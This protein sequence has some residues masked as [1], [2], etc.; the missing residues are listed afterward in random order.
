MNCT[1]YKWEKSKM[2]KIAIPVYEDMVAPSFDYSQK[3]LLVTL[4]NDKEIKRE[5]ILLK[6]FNSLQKAVRISDLRVEVLIC[7]AISAFA[8]RMLMNNGIRVIP[9]I[10]GEIDKIIKLYIQGQF[11]IERFRMLWGRF[12]RHFPGRRKRWRHR[13]PPPW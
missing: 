9:M 11:N 2:M 12:C 10:S 6:D 1:T 3:V 13:I 4:E 7:G 5:E 8:L